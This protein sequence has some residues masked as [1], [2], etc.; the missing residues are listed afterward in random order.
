[1]T[2]VSAASPGPPASCNDAAAR[3]CR[4]G[5]QSANGPSAEA[6]SRC[7]ACFTSAASCPMLLTISAKIRSSSAPGTPNALLA[8]IIIPATQRS[9][10]V[11]FAVRAVF[12]VPIG[13]SIEQS[14]EALLDAVCDIQR[15]RLDGAG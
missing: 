1:M 5:S 15:Q 2:L 4:A 7:S 14:G 9:D 13:A 12:S 8:G 3:A 10:L 11:S 6:S